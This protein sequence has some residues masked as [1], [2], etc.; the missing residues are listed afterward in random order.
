MLVTMLLLGAVYLFFLTVLYQAGT[1]VL[2][3]VVFA[4]AFLFAQYYFSDKLAL[5]SMGAREV[6]PADEPELHATVERLC[7]RSDIPK[8][9]IAVARSS[10]PN[11]FAT[12]RSPAKAVVAVTSGLLDRLDRGE[13]EA[14]LGH[15]LSHIG[16]RDVAVMTFASFLSTVAWFIIRFSYY[17]FSSRRGN[18]L[19]VVYLA[20]LLVYVLSFFLIRALSR[21]RELA[22]DRGSALLTGAPSQLASALTKIS[23]TMARIPDRDLR[24]VEGMNAFFILPAL[25]RSS[26]WT[27][28]AT[29]PPLE[30]RLGELSRLE[31]QMETTA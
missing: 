30:Q 28:V 18:P 31:Q 10:V 27:L 22:A 3:L 21:Y 17:G 26:L 29:H 20:S 1:S 23:G 2:G 19:V 9:R 6:S 24:E 13:I 12:G 5:A 4:G 11:A 25:R 14:V 16:N 8:P 15:E 7:T